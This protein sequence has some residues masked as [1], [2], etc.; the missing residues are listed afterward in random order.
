LKV[1]VVCKR[2]L[3]TFLDGIEG[4]LRRK[5]TVRR[6]LV[7]GADDIEAAFAW[8]DVVWCEWAN[9]VAAYAADHAK[10]PVVVRMH[11]YEAHSD[12]AFR[13]RWSNVKRLVVTSR[14][15]LEIARRGAPSVA[16]AN[17]VV[18]PSG[19]DVSR[20]PEQDHGQ[21]TRIGVVSYIHGRKQPGLWLQVLAALPKDYT[22]HVAGTVQEAPWQYYLAVMERELGLE[23]RV[24]YDGWV[25]DVA[26]W[27][28]DKDWCLSASMDE[29]CPYNVI[30]AMACGVRPVVHEYLGARDQFP[31]R[32]LWR[33]PAE[34]ALRI[35]RP[36]YDS[37]TPREW[38]D[39]HYSL[40]AQAEALL[41]TVEGAA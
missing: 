34:A 27:W 14:H 15:V 31:A 19:V 24:E 16:V 41:A 9:E 8:G 5:H 6:F 12:L 11:R 28:R 33:T 25:T 30:E 1:A 7:A 40:D 2:G 36:S 35:M 13:V 22:L 29:G 4:V 17:P 21:G 32:Y 39:R 3:D 10:R 38:V 18:I 37:E 26:A 23:G 20:F